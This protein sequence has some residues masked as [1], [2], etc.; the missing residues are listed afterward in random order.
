MQ[1]IQRFFMALWSALVRA[2]R[3]CARDIA[4]PKTLAGKAASGC[5]GLLAIL[6]VCSL[7]L[8]AVRSAGETAGLLPTRAPQRCLPRGQPRRR[9]RDQRLPRDRRPPRQ[10]RHPPLRLR[11]HWLCQPATP[12]RA[13]RDCPAPPSP[14]WSTATP[15][16]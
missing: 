6:C 12:Q 2:L 4:Q 13:L 7:G 3:F 14:A 5:L 9:R 1:L 8:S 10:H 11:Q 16:T 15:S